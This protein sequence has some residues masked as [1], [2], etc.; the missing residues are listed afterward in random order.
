MFGFYTSC[1]QFSA[2]TLRVLLDIA[3]TSYSYVCRWQA[4]S[5][6]YVQVSF[7]INAIRSANLE[8]ITGQPDTVLRKPQI[9]RNCTRLSPAAC[10]HYSSHVVPL[11]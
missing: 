3:S 8:S 4:N 10:P 9:P 1:H 5:T 11:D 6:L 7:H 2:D